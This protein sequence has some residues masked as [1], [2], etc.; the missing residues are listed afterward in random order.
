[1][2]NK[3]IPISCRSFQSTIEHH[4]YMQQQREHQT[5]PKT[6]YN[7]N[8]INKALNQLIFPYCDIFTI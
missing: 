4:H 7:V 2:R 1:M 8:G 3:A 6:E 5:T